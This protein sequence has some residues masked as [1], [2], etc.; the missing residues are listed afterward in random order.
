[1]AREFENLAKMEY[2]GRV[3]VIGKSLEGDGIVMYAIT[4]RSPSSQARLLERDRS[5]N[6]ILVK[7]TDEETLKSGDPDL[8]IYPAII[9]GEG[10]AVSNGK[11]TADIN[12]LFR[13]KKQPT[14]I[15]ASALKNWEYEPDEPNYTPR[16]SGCLFNGAALS[17]IKR[18]DDGSV[19][20]NYFE[21]PLIP[22]RGKMIATYTG[23]NENPLPS[24]FGEPVDVG[25]PYPDAEKA[26]QAMYEALGPDNEKDFRVAAV[27]VYHDTQ[28]AATIA[29]KNR[30]GR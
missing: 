27:A 9:I 15:L 18:E 20:R 19:L 24:F 1:M 6:R 13:E 16:I 26:A 29:I 14:E 23:I 17:I 25:L 8:L 11:Q 4:G 2:P 22:G 28:G 12:P 30:H 3:I 7:P 21:I 10:I 5:K